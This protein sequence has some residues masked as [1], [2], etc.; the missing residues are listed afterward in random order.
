VNRLRTRLVAVFFAATL[1]PLAVTLWLATSLLEHSLQYSQTNDLDELSRALE[2]TGRVFYQRERDALRRDALAGRPPAQR[3]QSADQPGW[4]AAVAEFWDSGQP[5]RFT[6][7]GRGGDRLELLMR[8]GEGVDLHTRDLGGVALERIREQYARAR[9]L[10]DQARDRDLRRGFFYVLLLFAG[11]P[12]IAAFAAL[13]YAGHR[14]TRPVRQLTAGLGRVAAGDL[15]AT[16]PTGGADEIG[17]AIGAFNRMAGELRRS[18][19]RLLYLARMESWQ[20]LARKM[21]HELKNSLTPIRLTTEEMIARNSHGDPRFHQQAAQI[22]VDEIAGLERRVRA[23]TDFA[24]EPPVRLAAVDLNALAAERIALLKPAHPG[25][26]YRLRL[27]ASL[28]EAWADEDLVRIVLTN[29][30]ENA[31]QAAG[32]GGAVLLAT[33]AVDGQPAVEVHDS[34][35][36][37][38]EEARATLF[39]PSI[40][41]KKGGMGLGLSIARRSAVLCGG[42]LSL[43]KGELGGAAFRLLLGARCPTP[44]S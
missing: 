37:L 23:F 24:A 38:S 14:I 18:R 4:P 2:S 6:L 1:P 22:I 10:V 28:P 3:Y 17:T 35:P 16:V 11:I 25:V 8:R 31:A 5:E 34:G 13:L 9:G 7:A 42:D 12:W 30:L 44:A 43:V 21:A 32:D 33:A 36:G 19:D 26:E 41:F 27:G 29:L 40:S 39:E 20:A 15:D